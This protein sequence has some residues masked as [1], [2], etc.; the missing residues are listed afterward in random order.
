MSYFERIERSIEVLF[1]HYYEIENIIGIACAF[2]IAFFII[3]II[4]T[5]KIKKL[6]KELLEF[7]KGNHYQS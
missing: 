7:K 5:R 4:N 2:L 1:E 3:T 6:E